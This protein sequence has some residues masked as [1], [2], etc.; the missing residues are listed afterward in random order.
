MLNKKEKRAI[1]SK[2][3]RKERDIPV[4]LHCAISRTAP[5]L[6]LASYQRKRKERKNGKERETERKKGIQSKKE[7]RAIQS[8]KERESMPALR[9]LQGWS[10]L[11]DNISEKERER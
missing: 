11:I 5:G 3:K 9:N 4:C 2:K 7:K 6:E 10:Y 8:K 1:Q